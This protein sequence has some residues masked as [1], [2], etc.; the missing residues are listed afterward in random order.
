MKQSTHQLK[1]VDREVKAL[2]NKLTLKQLDSISD[3]IITLVNNSEDE[4]GDRTLSQIIG[5]IYDNA[6]DAPNRHSAMYALLCR[7]LM[8]TINPKIQDTAIK[9]CEGAPIA[10]AQLFLKYLVTRLQHDIDFIFIRKR[11]MACTVTDDEN[12]RD[13]QHSDYCDAQ[14]AKRRGPGLAKFLSEMF[15]H[16]IVTERIMHECIKTLLSNDAPQEEVI[17]SL[18]QLLLTAGKILDVPEAR[19]DMDV[20]FERMRGLC[21]GSDISPRM[22]FMLQDVI[23]LRERGWLP[24]N[25][26]KPPPTTTKA[27]QEAHTFQRKFS[28]ARAKASSS[29][30][31]KLSP[32]A[33]LADET[34]PNWAPSQM[35][36]TDV[37]QPKPALQ[38]KRLQPFTMSVGSWASASPKRESNS[39]TETPETVDRKVRELLD[40]LTA[41]KFDS[42]SDQIIALANRSENEKDGQTL[43]QVIRLLLEKAT[44]EAN[45]SETYARL[46][47]KMMETISPKVQ[48]GSIKNAEGTPIA[49]GQLVCK[50][51][52]N[53]CQEDLERG[54]KAIPCAETTKAS[55]DEPI[56]TANEKKGD[57]SGCYSDEYYA[58]QKAKRQGLG[59]IKFIGELFK[60][61]M[62]TE[63]I[64][65][66]CVEK[67]LGSVQNP[68]EED[69]ES[70]SAPPNSRPT[71]ERSEC[72]YGR[73][74]SKDEEPLRE[75]QR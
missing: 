56:K 44:D 39:M 63:C 17:E 4:K 45:R 15:Q 33:E 8:E 31:S 65:Y 42:V 47:R 28:R 32:I 22:Q 51:L 34:K 53:R 7:R 59:L 36:G 48:D 74:L 75:R 11:A 20:Y 50:Y 40:K 60:L 6:I 35:P 37:G 19:A 62:L 41:E 66:E 14:L 67:F 69:I 16:R 5:L 1:G 25:A 18:C 21:K 71:L 46:C 73:V 52:L 9:D 10:G 30:F 54:W 13:K 26:V 24:R 3:Q 72:A 38:R 29:M 61:Q 57:E 55:A 70:V 2:L 58:S 64:M 23:E 49:G 12:N 27:P 68:E 43:M